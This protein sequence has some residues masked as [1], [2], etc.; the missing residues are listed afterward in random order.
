MASSECGSF[1]SRS[2]AATRYPTARLAMLLC[3]IC[4]QIAPITPPVPARWYYDWNL[5]RRNSARA[6]SRRLLEFSRIDAY[7]SSRANWRKD[8]AVQYSWL[9]TAY[10]WVSVWEFLN[11]G[12]LSTSLLSTCPSL[13]YWFVLEI[14]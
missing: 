9:S 6:L 5:L 8:Y 14:K 10:E 7:S 1:I 11:N 3:I 4:R 2:V 12:N 13:F